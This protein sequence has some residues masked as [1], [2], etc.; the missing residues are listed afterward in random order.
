MMDLRFW[1]KFGPW[2]RNAEMEH[3][4]KDLRTAA[5]MTEGS[6]ALEQE[7]RIKTLEA[8]SIQ[9]WKEI[10]LLQES[11]ETTE[12]LLVTQ[13]NDIEK[14]KE[15]ERKVK[16][17]LGTGSFEIDGDVLTKLLSDSKPITV[18]ED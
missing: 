4:M 13:H 5:N 2:K 9:I 11:L 1:K 10:R 6:A 14:L 3:E 15:F 18:K 12:S 8:S 7:K 17:V 16:L